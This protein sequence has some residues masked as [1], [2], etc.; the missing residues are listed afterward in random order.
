MKKIIYILTLLFTLFTFNNISYSAA[1]DLFQGGGLTAKDGVLTVP[2]L[3]VSSGVYTDANSKL[4]STPPSTGTLGFWLRSGT[5]LNPANTGDAIYLLATENLYMNNVDGANGEGVTLQWSGNVF[6]LQTFKTGTGTVRNTII[7]ADTLYSYNKQPYSINHSITHFTDYNGT[8][9]NTTEVTTTIAND[10]PAGTSQIY[11]TGT[12]SYNGA[13]TATFIDATNFYIAKIF[14][15]DDATGI[16]TTSNDYE[17]LFARWSGNIAEIGTEAGGSGIVRDIYINTL[18]TKTRFYAD[19]NHTT[20]AHYVDLENYPGELDNPFFRTNASFI[21]LEV[22]GPQ[23]AAVILDIAGAGLCWVAN[24]G[25]YSVQ[26]PGGAYTAMG[27]AGTAWTEYW[28]KGFVFTPFIDG[29]TKTKII[30]SPD[31]L[32]VTPIGTPGT[33]HYGYKYT[34]VAPGGGETLPSTETVTT[35]GNAVLDG[36]NNNY[37]YWT[38]INPAEINSTGIY[39]RIYRTTSTGTPSS[40]GLIYDGLASTVRY[41]TFYD[42]GI[43]ADTTK[44]PPTIDTSGSIAIVGNLIMQGPAS[45]GTGDFLNYNV[46]GSNYE[47]TYFRWDSNI[48]KI[49]TEAGGSGTG[50][51]MTLQAA[52]SLNLTSLGGNIYLTTA[53]IQA[54]IGSSDFLYGAG[55][56]LQIGP[57]Y[58]L[59]AHQTAASAAPPF[60]I[61]NNTT[62]N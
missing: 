4:T 48:F 29:G 45:G 44:Q 27:T 26:P 61:Y 9:P 46:T 47:R 41:G 17:R 18:G 59:L 16:M 6:N 21:G 52:G 2:S 33:D 38:T 10:L 54:N 60:W 3:S 12:T 20:P 24:G 7:Q 35:T 23:P 51:A 57:T 14:V 40:L 49:G 15:A 50:R 37:V 31:P 1:T 62:A 34:I 39:I 32:T 58:F 56:D 5:T 8:V 19:L 28:G 42:T 43:A 22:N 25:L 36:T 55:L 13:W 53:Y 11:I 30:A